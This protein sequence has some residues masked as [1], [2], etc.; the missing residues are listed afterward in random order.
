MG[1]AQS[2]AT[3]AV[4]AA[5]REKL[6]ERVGALQLNEKTRLQDLEKDYVYLDDKMRR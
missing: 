3:P 4:E 6:I 5:I 1:S 2:S